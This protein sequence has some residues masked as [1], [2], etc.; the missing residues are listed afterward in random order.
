MAR[1][2]SFAR[3][4]APGQ[5]GNHP[6][7]KWPMPAIAGRAAHS[8]TSPSREASTN[9]HRHTNKLPRLFLFDVWRTWSQWGQPV[10]E[11]VEM[12]KVA[13]DFARIHFEKKSNFDR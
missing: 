8:N 12:V 9:S 11:A 1:K 5:E 7:T 2:P 13:V 10:E 4:D 6:R 3:F